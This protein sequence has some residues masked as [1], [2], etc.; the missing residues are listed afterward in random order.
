M[1]H[2]ELVK[3]IFDCEHLAGGEYWCFEHLRAERFDDGRCKGCCC[4]PTRRR[5][6]LSMAK[7][8]FSNLGHKSK[9]KRELAA[10][11]VDNDSVFLCP[12]PSYESLHPNH[13]SQELS[14]TNEI[15]ELPSPD[16]VPV[17]TVSPPGFAPEVVPTVPLAEA[18]QAL[19]NGS[20]TPAL[21]VNEG[22]FQF[23][24]T[25]RPSLQLNTQVGNQK[26]IRP[27]PAPRSKNLSP[28]SSVRS[29]TSTTSTLSNIS[30]ISTTSSKSLVSP[31]SVWSEASSNP[32]AGAPGYKTTAFASP[33]YTLLPDE[34]VT[35]AMATPDKDDFA[36]TFT[37]DFGD[38]PEL[39]ELPGE[40]SFDMEGNTANSLNLDTPLLGIVPMALENCM[41]DPA[42]TTTM[43]IAN[44]AIYGSCTS[45][46][47]PTSVNSPSFLPFTP[48]EIF[49]CSNYK[50]IIDTVWATL[51]EALRQSLEKL[52]Q[53]DSNPL[54]RKMMSLNPK[55][56][57]EWG[58]EALESVFKSHRNPADPIKA[59]CL[60]HLVYAFSIPV[61][62]K[63][64]MNRYNSLFFESLEYILE[65][66]EE[67]RGFYRDVV[68]ILW[69]PVDVTKEEVER[70]LANQLVQS[71][72]RSSSFKGKQ[73]EQPIE[74][75]SSGKAIPF[76]KVA[77]DF[78]D[79]K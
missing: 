22:A 2:E 50:N 77:Q 45:S 27:P 74:I 42:T 23:T 11:A 56:V 47:Q 33:P 16:P 14:A 69:Q 75:T 9:N 4:H 53:I 39:S 3:H 57:A 7:T 40:I 30:T 61:Y 8:F 66:P 72:S 1:S 5:K 20:Q 24:E 76:V 21:L 78:F 46:Q 29:T 59:L 13:P 51:G 17:Q 65:L 6:I 25:S 54:A 36:A 73:R 18:T 67:S 19:M 26:P 35:E 10:G 15:Y 38:I 55:Q 79:G 49:T 48:D 31:I 34:I 37:A 43:P 70:C 32:F 63:H 64:A 58:I 12:P 44:P 68:S 52:K 71:L 62:E 28:S 41:H 60:V